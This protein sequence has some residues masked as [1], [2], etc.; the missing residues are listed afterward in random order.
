VHVF[1]TPK[2]IQA[3]ALKI[4]HISINSKDNLVGCH[5]RDCSGARGCAYGQNYIEY[6]S[7]DIKLGVDCKPKQ[8]NT[9]P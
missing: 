3:S 9:G 7:I 6:G 5:C 4:N 1:Q 8:L 2:D